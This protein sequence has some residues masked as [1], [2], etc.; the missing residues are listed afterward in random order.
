M[1]AIILKAAESCRWD[2]V[3]LGEVMLRLDPG[4]ERIHTALNFRAWEG[5]ENITLRTDSGGALTCEPP[6]L[7]R[8]PGIP[9][10][11]GQLVEDLMLQGAV[12]TS[13]VRWVPYDGIG[14]TVRNGLNFTERGF[15]LCDW[16]A[17]A[18]YER[19]I[20]HVPQRPLE[21]LDRGGCGDSFA[22]GLIYGFLAGKDAHWAVHCGVAHGALVMTTPGDTSMATLSEVEV[23]MRGGSTRIAR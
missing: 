18:L 10:A 5:A 17:V 1:N 7:Q 19:N 11:I 8:W 4:E 22:S 13:L 3:S 6:S 9:S 16:G 2:C 12:G 21:I 14:R 20:I 15:G 23:V